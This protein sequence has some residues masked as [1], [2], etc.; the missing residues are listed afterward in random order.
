MGGIAVSALKPHLTLPHSRFPLTTLTYTGMV[1][2]GRV[3]KTVTGTSLG[4]TGKAMMSM[5]TTVGA[6]TSEYR[7]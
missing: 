3:M 7:M 6:M 4:M 2:I 1:I 5:A